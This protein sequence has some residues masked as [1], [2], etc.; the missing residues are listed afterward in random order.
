MSW[1]NYVIDRVLIIADVFSRKNDALHAKSRYE[2]YDMV[3]RLEMEN[4]RLRLD[5]RN[6][7]RDYKKFFEEFLLRSAGNYSATQWSDLRSNAKD[8][9]KGLESRSF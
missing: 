1:L 4:D 3:E 8:F 9:L 5:M 7:S 2:L 6:L